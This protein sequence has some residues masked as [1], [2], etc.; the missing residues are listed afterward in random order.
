MQEKAVA[1]QEIFTSL[2]QSSPIP[3]FKEKVMMSSL[4]SHSVFRKPLLA[5]K[6]I[7][8]LRIAVLAASQLP[9]G[10]KQEKCYASKEKALL[11]STAAV[12][13]T[14]SSKLAWKP[15]ST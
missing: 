4:N 7:Y 14:C 2:L 15:P 3:S 5:V 1:L 13:E 11:M 6:R 12:A 9:K 8:P 10:H